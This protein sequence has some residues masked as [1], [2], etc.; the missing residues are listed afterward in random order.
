[1]LQH[2][3]QFFAITFKLE[4]PEYDIDNADALPGAKKILLTC[5]GIGFTNMNKRTN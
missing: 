5:V 1:M 3:A 2:L 4:S